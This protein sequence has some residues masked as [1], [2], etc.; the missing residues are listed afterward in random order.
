[1]AIGP[2][3]AAADPSPLADDSLANFAAGTPGT[4]TWAVEP[5][6]VRLKPTTLSENFDGAGPALPTGWTATAWPPGGGTG[7]VGG[8]T[9]TVDGA[10]VNDGNL[11]PTFSAPQTLEFRATFGDAAFQHVG[12]GDTFNDG[13]W[14]MFSTGSTSPV[15]TLYARALAVAGGVEPTPIA[16]ASVNPLVAHTYRIEWSATDVKY[17]VDDALVATQPGAIAGPMRPVASDLTPDAVNL[18]VEWFSMGPTPSSGTFISH[19]LAADGA[20]TVWGAVKETGLGSGAAFETR[21]GNTATPDSTWSD[22]Q[23]V[24]TAG[25]IQSPS[26]RQYIQY[27]ATLSSATASL[28]KV[29]IDYATDTTA[30]S[31]AIDSVQVNGTTAKITFSSSASDLDGFE[32]SVDGAAYAACMSPKELTGLAVGSHTVFVRAV[33]KAGNTGTGVSKSFGVD[34][35][36]SGGSTNVTSGGASSA[37]VAADKTA[38]KVTVVG[39]SL[40]ASKHGT[41]SFRVGCP[42]GETRCKVTLVLKRGGSVAASKTVTV[43][44]GK[45]VT[46]TLQLAKA[47]RKQLHSHGSLKVTAVITAS[48]AAGNKKTAKQSMTL[49]AP[50]A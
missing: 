45:T 7:T 19:V 15:T 2:A 29:A 40:R 44:G 42:A 33:D 1:M 9:L 4:A 12:F 36:A 13:P 18:K 14:A 23:A 31:A 38:P 6:I 35:P 50:K 34:P 47:I 28:D 3:Y 27:K 10:H 11:T 32:C 21:S 25:A 41:V 26:G 30:P 22:W 16:I 24:G 39:K 46:V 17:Y 5:G 20:H 37:V 8:G 49:R 43:Q 48:D